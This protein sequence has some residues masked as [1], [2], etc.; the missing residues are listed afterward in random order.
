MNILKGLWVRV[1]AL[2]FREK[3]EQE[4]EDEIRFHLDMETEQLIH[5]SLPPDEARRKALLEF[6]GVERFKEKTRAARSL[7]VVEDLTRSLRV[8]LRRLASHAGLR[9]YRYRRHHLCGG[10]RSGPVHRGSGQPASRPSGVANGS[11]HSSQ[12]RVA[13]V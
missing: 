10:H 11:R 2:L 9:G 8:G 13:A 1:R 7:P 6:G 12:G 3:V 4:L 5:R